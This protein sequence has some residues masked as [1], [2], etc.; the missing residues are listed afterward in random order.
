MTGEVGWLEDDSAVFASLGEV[1]VPGREEIMRAI[2][3]HV[4]AGSDNE[5]LA[6]DI[7][8][9]SGWLS[10]AILR[11][12]PGSRVLALD[13]SPAMLRTA[14]QALSGYRDR[15]R[16]RAFRLE[17]PGWPAEV[18]GSVRCFVSTLVLHHLDAAGK[19][20]LFRSL[21]RRLDP[22]GALLYADLVEPASEAG[23][24]H[25]ARLWDG[26]V[27]R[28]S[29]EIT[30]NYRAYRTFREKDWNWYEHPD[31]TDKPSGIVE[32]LRWLAEAGFGRLDLPWARAGHA[33][34]C[35]FKPAG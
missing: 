23:W 14:G 3:D 11:E 4:P 5:F 8:C 35:A 13:G 10:E 22:G 26:E 1:F 25:A 20:R 24:R 9:G 15:V 19:R 12:V 7:G 30:G 21:W 17:D 34:F 32:Q 27:E 6:V 2:L 28:R 33:V 18:E 29:R 16:L 31:P